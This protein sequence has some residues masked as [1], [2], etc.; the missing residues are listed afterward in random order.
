[1]KNRVQECGTFERHR[2]F[3]AWY[4]IESGGSRL[5]VVQV[6]MRTVDSASVYLS[7]KKLKRRCRYWWR[8]PVAGFWLEAIFIIDLVKLAEVGCAIDSG[9]EVP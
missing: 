1:M 5:A 8:A 7:S 2:R 6:V 3:S 9:A 4:L